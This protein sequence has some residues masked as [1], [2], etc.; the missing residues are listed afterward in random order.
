MRAATQQ[1][2]LTLQMMVGAVSWHYVR[3]GAVTADVCE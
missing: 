2:T 3:E 1:V